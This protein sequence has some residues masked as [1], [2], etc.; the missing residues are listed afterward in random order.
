[1]PRVTK[2]NVRACFVHQ[3]V[4]DECKERLTK[5]NVVSFDEVIDALHLEAMADAIHWNHI[6]Q[7][8]YEDIGKRLIPLCQLY[9]KRHKIEEEKVKPGKFTAGTGGQKT[10]V[11]LAWYG[12]N[13]CHLFQHNLVILFNQVDGKA[14][15]YSKKREDLMPYIGPDGSPPSAPMLPLP[16]VPIRNSAA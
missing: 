1:M 15:S 2:E 3:K 7:I 16:P 10:M 14:K 6:R 12:D 5:R 8:L 9:F 11:G 13:T 4:I